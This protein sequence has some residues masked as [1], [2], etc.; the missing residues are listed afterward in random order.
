[1]TRRQAQHGIVMLEVLITV[2]ILAFGLLGLAGIQA[3]M[4]VAEMEAYQR[5]QATVLL[6]DMSDRLQSNG[7]NATSYV[8]TQPLGTGQSIGDCSALAS[9]ALDRCE[10]SNA[11]LGA[12]ETAATAKVGAMIDARGCVEVLDNSMP[13]VF[14]VSVAWQGLNSTTAPQ[15]SSCGSNS[16]GNENQRRVIVAQ[17]IIACLENHPVGHPKAG[18]CTTDNA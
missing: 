1:M 10:W 5:A 16:Y 2:V 8:T 9:A 14:R 17:V 6:R 18:Q 3:R 4:H 11:L 13:R 15:A 7:K 12:S